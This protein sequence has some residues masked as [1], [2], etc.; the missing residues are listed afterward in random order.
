[1][2]GLLYK[3][4]LAVR[5]RRFLVFI[6]IITLIFVILRVLFP[7]TAYLEDFMVV[8]EKGNEIN[9]IDA[10]LLMY[11][12]FNI[13]MSADWINKLVSRVVANDE[14]NKIR[15]YLF[16]MPVRKKK[17]IISKYVGILAVTGFIFMVFL[18]WFGVYKSFMGEVFK[19]DLVILLEKFL[20]SFLT[21]GLLIASF[22]LPMYLFWG[23]GKTMIIKISFLMLCG[24]F[25]VGFLLFGDLSV[26]AGID[27]EKIL[28][29]A[30]LHSR[31]IK[32]TAGH[33]KGT[34]ASF[35]ADL[36]GP[37]C[38]MI[39]NEGSGLSEEASLAADQ[40]VRIPMPG[41]AESLNAA[42]AAGMLMYETV[43]QRS[44]HA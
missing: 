22:E 24:F 12:V 23:R 35:E 3:D 38:L 1:M 13:I 31:G 37:V 28:I 42:M 29:W 19:R 7:G 17:Y 10:F 5:G 18:L 44:I 41:H 14:K 21:L 25:V 43:R 39:G 15:N 27:V 16:S 8:D 4:F 30:A 20:P 32:L 40:L 26:F 9:V 36:T 34:K 2:A 6:A 11:I 33:L